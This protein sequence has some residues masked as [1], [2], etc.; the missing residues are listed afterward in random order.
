M[1][2]LIKEFFERPLSEAESDSLSH[3]LNE[4][5][6]AALRFEGLLE[7]H[8]LATGLPSPEVPA[9]LNTPPRVSGGLGTAAGLK[10]SA[11]LVAAGLLAW[12]FWPSSITLPAV[13]PQ[14]PAVLS[15]APLSKNTETRPAH[16]AR[17]LPVQPQPAG[18]TVEGE[19]LSV[20]VG[21]QEKTLVTVRILN[22]GGK[23]VRELY[24]GF[25]QP[26]H[27]SFRWDGDL[28]DGVPA[29]AGDY[30]IDVQTG[31]LHQTKNIRI[32]PY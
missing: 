17:V 19:E 13:K 16:A 20:V 31:D 3:L 8:Y 26:G 25:I 2:D 12:K 11:L 18:P 7:G 9:S 32:K 14:A 10:F 27:W 22:N 28:S 15:T 1:A 5:P 21:V 6:D 24:T 30:Q 23:E 29:A 4:S